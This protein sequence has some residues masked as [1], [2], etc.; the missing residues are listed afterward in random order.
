MEVLG[1]ISTP[2]GAGRNDPNYEERSV[3]GSKDI[4]AV[5]WIVIAEVDDAVSDAEDNV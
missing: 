2:Q 3:A 4:Q 5:H 1:H